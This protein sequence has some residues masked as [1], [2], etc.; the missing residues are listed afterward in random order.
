MTDKQPVDP[1]TTLAGLVKDLAGV[2]KDLMDQGELGAPAD[3][4]AIADATRP[5]RDT[6]RST[7]G[8]SAGGV[9]IEVPWPCASLAVVGDTSSPAA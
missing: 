7:R 2:V 6:T 3:R 5:H 8:G 4:R 1:V 9:L